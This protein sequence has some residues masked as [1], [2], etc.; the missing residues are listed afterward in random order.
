MS[1]ER[2]RK[3]AYEASMIGG[4]AMRL[5]E[6]DYMVLQE[7]DRWRF[8][9]SRHLCYLGGFGS[10]SACDKRLRKLVDAGYIDHK[11]MLYG[12]A[13]EYF[14]TYKG[15]ALLG[16]SKRLD[17]IRV[18]R[19]PHDI[20]VL[21]TVIYF[22]LKEGVSLSDI[23]SEKQMHGLDGFT[24]RRH[25]PD[26]IYSTAGKTYCVEVELSPKSKERFE[27]N[28]KQNFYEYEV[29]H[30]VV[31]KAQVKITE[32]LQQNSNTYP[33]IKIITLEEVKTYVSNLG[34]SES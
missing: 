12:V 7:L 6:R 26:F 2:A 3:R 23:Q 10:R 1:R 33:N 29:Q 14:L 27:Q 20:A 4:V 19:I 5:V 16:Q 34:K 21:D 32:M 24:R 11:R 31:S 28:L 13:G 18:D 22:M 8:C 15:K 30:W 25:R 17:T 9:L